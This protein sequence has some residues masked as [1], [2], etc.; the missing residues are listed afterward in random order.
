MVTFDGPASAWT[1]GGD[2]TWLQIT[3]GVGNT[4][5]SFTVA[6]VNPE[7]VIGGSTTLTGAIT[8]E[9][10]NAPNSPLSIPVTLKIDHGWGKNYRVGNGTGEG[11]PVKL[12]SDPQGKLHALQSRADS[13]RYETQ[14]WS[15]TDQGKTWGAPVSINPADETVMLLPNIAV[16]SNRAINIVWMGKLNDIDNDIF[17]TRSTDEGATWSANLD[18]IPSASRAPNQISPV[19]VADPRSGQGNTLIVA[20]RTS[21]FGADQIFTIRST[22]GGATW[23]ELVP[24]P[25]PDTVDIFKIDSLNLQMDASGKLYLVFDEYMVGENRIFFT[26][27]LDGG[28]SW[29]P[30]QPITPMNDCGVAGIPSLMLG[31]TGVVYVA[32]VVKNLANTC[33]RGDTDQLQLMLIKSQDSGDN[34]SPSSQIGP[35]NLSGYFRNTSGG[36]EDGNLVLEVIP[37]QA[38]AGD[39]ELMV[40][41]NNDNWLVN[42]LYTAK[43]SVVRSIH[44]MDGGAHWDATASLYGEVMFPSDLVNAVD[45]KHF[46]PDTV[47]HQGQ[48]LAVWVDERVTN[49][50]YPFISAFG[51]PS[52]N[53][54]SLFL[55]LV[56]K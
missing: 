44:S 42:G 11:S 23:G 6:I 34:W 30:V 22:D 36:D 39:D 17:F 47:V 1:A 24:V 12:A 41:W 54:Y 10:P 38:G 21:D 4:P 7:N 9:A 8:V 15:S 14:F 53:S 51:A 5:G 45:L 28:S 46:Y 37:H 20:M 43:N 26:R 49:W 52:E 25:Y 40:V 55:P 48:V 33:G 13:G 2:Q 32:Y 31:E 29:E 18:I 19:I 35:L 56:L 50:I 27:S 16:G 3:G